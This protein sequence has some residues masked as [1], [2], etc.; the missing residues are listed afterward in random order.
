MKFSSNLVNFSNDIQNPNVKRRCKQHFS[1]NFTTLLIIKLE[2]LVGEKY[3]NLTVY[4]RNG[5]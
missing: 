5:V 2:G 4:S 3:Q 1:H